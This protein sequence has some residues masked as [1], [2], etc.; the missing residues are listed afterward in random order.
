MKSKLAMLTTVMVLLSAAG[1]VWAGCGK[2]VAHKGAAAK[3]AKA[4]CA[5]G[6]VGGD[7]GCPEG[8]CAARAAKRR[9]AA[10]AA[11]EGEHKAPALGTE[12]LSVL[13][14]SGVPLVLLDA[15]SGK[16]DDGRRI[17]GARSLNSGSSKKEIAKTIGGKDK[18]VVTYCS[19]VKCQA[20]PKL[21]KK[22]HE[23]GYKNILEYPKGINGWEAAGQKV[24]E[25]R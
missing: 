19:N 1:I 17:P 10:K 12:Q 20:S 23:L 22:L 4:L 21:A 13:L 6:G 7:A 18:L 14:R 25:A 8:A 2:C 11:A 5:K 15:R 9:K 16:W 24:A 3:E